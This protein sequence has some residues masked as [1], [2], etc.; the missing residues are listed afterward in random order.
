MAMAL[1]GLAK[2][3]EE[4]GEVLQVVGKLQNYPGGKHPDGKGNLFLRLEEEIADAKAAIDFV[5][6]SLQLNHRNID[7]RAEIKLELFQK[8]HKES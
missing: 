3:T 8:W 2:L 6:D 7:A 4:F 5:I 1:N